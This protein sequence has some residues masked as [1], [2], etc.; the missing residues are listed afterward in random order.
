MDD[1]Y[2][3]RSDPIGTGQNATL[4]HFRLQF[5]DQ[6]R[7]GVPMYVT[8]EQR[9]EFFH[10]GYIILKGVVPDKLVE[11]AQSRIKNA[12]KGENL[13]AAN[14]ITDLVNKSYVTPILNEMMG[15]FDPPSLC[16]VGILS[17][18]HI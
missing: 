13:M 8:D 5:G 14:E 10:R 11:K 2:R 3:C 7:I 15:E 9:Q 1:I 17:L 12:E 6:R 4:L 16:Q 18:I